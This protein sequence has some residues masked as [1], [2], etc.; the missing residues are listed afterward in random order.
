MRRRIGAALLV[1]LATAVGCD[2]GVGAAPG[3]PATTASAPVLRI[4]LLHPGRENDGGW[5]ELAYHALL[6]LRDAGVAQVQHTLTINRATFKSE[7]RDYAQSGC[8]IVIAHGS[9]YVKAAREI[10]REFPRTKFVVTGSGDG[11][12]GVVTLDFRLW[13]ATYLCGVL[14]AGLAPGGPAGLIGAEDIVTVRRTMDAFARGAQSVEPTYRVYAQYVGSWDDIARAQQTARSLIE[15]RGVKVIFQ[16]VDAAARGVFEAASAAGVLAFG[17]NSDQS[18]LAPTLVPASAVIRMDLAFR[19][20]ADD[21]RQDRWTDGSVSCDLRSGLIDVLI[22]P[23]FS[24]RINAATR[25]AF[26]RAR[27]AIVAGGLDVLGGKP[28][29]SAGGG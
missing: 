7:M 1:A 29:G 6:Q 19:R 11:G 2:R 25:G 15:T 24:Q 17:C 9:E 12:E 26:E 27:A 23:A 10:A 16:N 14:A 4:A 20:L 13:E 28:A 3:A 18:A 5:N 21:V 22:N 8:Q